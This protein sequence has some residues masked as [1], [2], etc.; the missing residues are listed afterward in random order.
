M[1]NKKLLKQLVT[2]SYK[3]NVLDKQTV[4][5]IAD[6][7]DR[8]ELRQYIKALKEAK[9]SKEVIVEVP[10]A[11]KF[12]Q[13]ELENIFPNKELLIKEDPS[14]LLGIRIKNND[15]IIEM[16]LKNSLQTMLNQITQE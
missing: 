14:L 4:T 6:R 16:N 3:K 1:I 12:D 11:Q 10:F 15:D 7:L 9:R 13:K 8:T 5:S 2:A